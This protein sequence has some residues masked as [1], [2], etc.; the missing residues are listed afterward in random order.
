MNRRGWPETVEKDNICREL[1]KWMTFGFS[2][3]TTELI[4]SKLIKNNIK[5]GMYSCR[6]SYKENIYFDYNMFNGQV[7]AV[8]SINE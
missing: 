6:Y 2:L 4:T 1:M 7:S 5:L 8:T 3:E